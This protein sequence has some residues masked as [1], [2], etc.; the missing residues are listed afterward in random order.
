MRNETQKTSRAISF[1]AML[2]AGLSKESRIV[3]R[4]THRVLFLKNGGAVLLFTISRNWIAV[5]I[6]VNLSGFYCCHTSFV[7]SLGSM[8]VNHFTTVPTLFAGAKGQCRNNGNVE[9][10]FFH[11]LNFNQR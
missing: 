9:E 11:G 2:A 10:N 5:Y 6:C 1:K 3:T 4:K 8:T 7:A